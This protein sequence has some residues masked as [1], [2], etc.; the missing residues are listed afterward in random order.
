MRRRARLRSIPAESVP[1]LTSW[2]R[3]AVEPG[4]R[5]VI[6]AMTSSPLLVGERAAG[7]EEEEERHREVV[8]EAPADDDP[9]GGLVHVVPEVHVAED[10]LRRLV[11]DQVFEQPEAEEED[12]HGEGDDGGDELAARERRGEEA[13][14]QEHGADPQDAHVAGGDRPPVHR[15]PVGDDAGVGEGGEPEEEVEGE[16]RQ[17]LARHHLAL[18]HRRRHQDLD[19]A[20]PQ[21]LREEPHGDHRPH[22]EEDQP[23]EE[24]AA[25]EER[26]R[27]TAGRARIVQEGDDH[28]EDEAVDDEEEEEHHVGE[29][30]EEVGPQLAVEGR[31]DGPHDD[32]SWA[33]GVSGAGGGTASGSAAR[34]RVVS[35]TKMSSS[36]AFSAVSSRSTQPRSTAARKIPSR[37]SVARDHSTTSE[38]SEGGAVAAAA[39]M[40][41]AAPEGRTAVTPA[42]PASRFA[43]PSGAPLRVTRSVGFPTQLWRSVSG[44]PW[45]TIFPRS[46]I[47]T[48]SQRSS[49]SGRMRVDSRSVRSRPS[50][51]ISSR[52]A[53]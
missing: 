15:A 28:R 50:S 17:V 8:D 26:Q 5:S 53:M 35:R 38:V 22:E 20:A 51:R 48:R 32:T 49:T 2:R 1:V 18:G 13:D 24:G 29:R 14:G 36:E 21:L 12:Q 33:A 37:T 7:Q 45:A 31:Q 41:V 19:R 34:A 9:L 30:R 43:A 44:V 11:V 6:S 16:G 3:L 4:V 52:M 47:S 40:A 46:M 25:E 10:L 23:E 39:A 27:R 42:I